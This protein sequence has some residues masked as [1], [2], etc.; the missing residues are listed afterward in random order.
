MPLLPDESELDIR[1]PLPN[2]AEVR[3]FQELCEAHFGVLPNES[4][5]LRAA[6]AVVRL[7]YL[8]DEST[9]KALSASAQESSSPCAG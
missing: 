2:D 6:T 8:A 3:R 1:L 7:V 4:D 5:A 9:R